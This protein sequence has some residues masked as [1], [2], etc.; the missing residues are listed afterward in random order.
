MATPTFS[1]LLVD[2]SE[3]VMTIKLH[4]PKRKNAF[5]S[6]MYLDVISALQW[7]TSRDD[8]VVALLTGSG[9]YF[10]SGNDLS[11]FLNIPDD[12]TPEQLSKKSGDMLRQFIRAFID[13]PKPL[14]A[15]VNGPAIGIA[16]TLLGLCDI[17]YASESATFQTPFSKLA[18]TPEATSSFLFP[19]IMG[20]SRANEV[21]LLGKVLTAAE[22]ER[23]NYVSAVF[24][25]LALEQE[26]LARAKELAQFPVKSLIYS[27]QLIRE[28]IKS[29]LY[30]VNENEC[31]R[32]EERW[33]SPDIAEALMKFMTRKTSKL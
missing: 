11:N 13:F 10:S 2:V 22:A 14:I 26:V 17:V 31:V 20:L 29:R 19:R 30:Q 27:K 4:R 1:A 5:N 23:A 21:L 33:V 8:V 6:E 3:G 32:L 24:P 18:Q 7:A 25:R 28:P 15:A 16:V 12:T 9:D